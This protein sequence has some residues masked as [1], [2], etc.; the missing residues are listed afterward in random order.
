[1]KKCFFLFFAITV[2]ISAQNN[3]LKAVDNIMYSYTNIASIEEL[4]K[5]IDYDFETDIEKVRAIFT[6][7]SLNIQYE[8]KNPYEI[9]VPKT[10]FVF[11]EDDFK[12]RLKKEQAIK[13]QKTFK[14][15][16]GVC[17]GYALLFQKVCDLLNIQNELIYGYVRSSYNRIGYVPKNKNHVWNA[18]KI[19][20][21][22]IFMDATWAAGYVN[23]GIWHS[24]LN[25]TYF[26]ID[27]ETLRLTHFPAETFW[28]TY[29]NQKP[30]KEFCYQPIITKTFVASKASLEYPNQGII[31]VEKN[32]SIK[33]NIKN[34]KPNTTLL[35]KF[36]N[37][38]EMKVASSSTKNE[39]TSIKIKGPNKSNA[40]HLYFNNSHALSYKVE[41]E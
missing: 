2:S 33:L 30:L 39:V 26:N 27:K 3:K 6:W 20:N 19:H 10:Y 37:N 34:L 13:A 28:L 7:I 21:K 11:N 4:A 1:M 40:L 32:G 8:L 17:D 5:R 15:K 18:V 12:R 31:K 9:D 14:T 38:G 25:T 16:R 36:G 35:Y 41:I 24:K 23:S 22:W 29:L